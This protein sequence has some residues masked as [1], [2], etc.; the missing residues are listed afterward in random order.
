MTGTAVLLGGV[1][2]RWQAPTLSGALAVALVAFSQLAPYAVGLPRW[3][4]LG[5]TGALLLAVGA[6]YEQRRADLL[7]GTR[8]M[9][10]LH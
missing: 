1:A 4:T 3:L 2:K 10:G 5:L 9:A 6:R 8:W 7:R